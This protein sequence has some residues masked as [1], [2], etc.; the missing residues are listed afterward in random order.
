M[1]EETDVILNTETGVKHDSEKPPAA[2]LPPLS[3]LGAARVLGMGAVKYSAHN[4]RGGIKYSRLLSAALRHL[5]AY[6]GGEDT[7][8]ES[9]LSHIHHAV[10]NLMF[11]GEFI[12]TGRVELDDRY[13]S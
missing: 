1:T 12:E 5:L 4:W 2:L 3:L 11:L 13:K 6:I 10:V 8:K 9:G 7:D